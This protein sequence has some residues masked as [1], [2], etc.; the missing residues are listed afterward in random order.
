MVMTKNGQSAQR[1]RLCTY[2]LGFILNF[3]ERYTAAQNAEIYQALAA[4]L[5]DTRRE[6]AALRKELEQ[7][8]V[9][10]HHLLTAEV[11]RR[12]ALEQQL[13]TTNGGYEHVSICTTD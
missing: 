7:E 8:C 12:Q 1:P 9:R 4:V 2:L 13:L 5:D 11:Q 3:Q 10:L 6:Q